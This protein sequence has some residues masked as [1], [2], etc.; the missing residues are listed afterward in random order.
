MP[1]SRSVFGQRREQARHGRFIDMQRQRDAQPRGAF[2]H[3]R[4]ADGA[5]VIA[6]CL[7]RRGQRDGA[8]DRRR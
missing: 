8:P 4:R 5:D 3:G 1:A 2:R 7:Q 6:P